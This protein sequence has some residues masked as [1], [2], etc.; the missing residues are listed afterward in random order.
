MRPGEKPKWIE[1]P[2][3]RMTSIEILSVT[4]LPI[5]I[6]PTLHALRAGWSDALPFPALSLCIFAI[7]MMIWFTSS[8]LQP[9]IREKV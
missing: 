8:W 4:V 6:G 3:Q 2:D 7:Y 5:L 1:T 9:F